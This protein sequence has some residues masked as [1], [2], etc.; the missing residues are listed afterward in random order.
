M[1]HYLFIIFLVLF[2]NRG[3][4]QEQGLISANHKHSPALVLVTLSPTCPMCQYYGPRLAYYDSLL[5]R[6]NMEL[7]LIFP[8]NQQRKAVQQY[9]SDFH[10]KTLC[11]PRNQSHPYIDNYH[12]TTTPE[13]VFVDNK[14]DVLYRGKI[15]NRYENI[16]EKRA[17]ATEYYLRDAILAFVGG[18]EISIKE[19][20]AVGCIISK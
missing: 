12:F 11:V 10:V 15:D 7:R 5:R 8:K 20:Q 14:G 4:T 3:Y 6:N 19:T 1:P 16:G 17:F 2:T 18:R 13:C 9:L